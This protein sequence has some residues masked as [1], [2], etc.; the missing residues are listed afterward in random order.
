VDSNSR[1]ANN[2]FIDFIGTEF[3]IL[4]KFLSEVKRAPEGH[5][6]GYR[7]LINLYLEASKVKDTLALEKFPG[8]TRKDNYQQQQGFLGLTLSAGPLM[9]KREESGRNHSQ[10]R[11]RYRCISYYCPLICGFDAWRNRFFYGNPHALLLFWLERACYHM[12]D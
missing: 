4:N 10:I 2:I 12:R 6:C 8:R 5:T 7:E 11:Y 9:Q 3:W 1:A